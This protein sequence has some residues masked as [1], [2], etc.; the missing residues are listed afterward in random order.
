MTENIIIDNISKSFQDKKV[1]SGFSG[2]IKGGKT[3]CLFGPSGSGKTTLIR[4]L[5][6]LETLDDGQILNI[7]GLK[8]SAVFQEDRLCENLSSV[9]NVKM[10]M[11]TDIQKADELLSEL[12]LEENIHQKVAELS[13]GM[14]RRVAIAR[15]LA[16]EY[17]LLVLDEPFKGL[18]N[19]N[20]EDTIKVVKEQSEGK[21]VIL[22]TH[23]I[24]EAELLGTENYIYFN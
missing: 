12:G 10:V 24:K 14:K 15:A 2:I 21:T 16:S 13:G 17:D 1:L 5:L 7:D 3:N 6:N 11:N 9:I 8:K 23:D 19:K 22:V 20:K 4:L 18:D